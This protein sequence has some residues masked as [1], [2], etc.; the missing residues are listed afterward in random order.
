MTLF[1]F[2][3]HWFALCAAL[4]V[5][6]IYVA[7]HLAFRFSPKV[8]Y[9]GIPVLQTANED[10]Y[11]TRIREVIDGHY[12]TG[13]FTFY[14]YKDK[15]PLTP[16]TIEFFYALP[17][18]LFDIPY[19][20]TAVASRF[21]LPAILFVLVY[22]L[23]FEMTKG[24]KGEQVDTKERR[25]KW[26]RWNALA[27]A[28]VVTLGYDLVDYRALFHLL[29]TG[30][31]TTSNLLFWS[32]LVH[33][34]SGAVLLF[35]CLLLTWFLI[36]GT[37]YRKWV[38]TG[39]GACL[40]LMF[41]SY[42][43][44]WGVALSV[45]AVATLIY[46]LKKEYAIVRNLLLSVAAGM[47]LST[48]YWILVFRTMQEPLYE[49]SALR[50]GL[51]Y[52]HY[53]LFNKFI[54]GALALFL[55]LVVIMPVLNAWRGSH[56][57]KNAMRHVVGSF[58]PWHFFTL[59]LLLGSFWV[60]VEQVVTGI[61]AWPPHFPQYTI[62]VGLVVLF[63][64]FFNQVTARFP[65]AW[66]SFS[67]FIA[68]AALVYGIFIQTYVYR[69]T[70]QDNIDLERIAPMLAFLDAVK[71]PCVALV[72]KPSEGG[73]NWNFIVT[74]F[75]HCDTYAGNGVS[76]IVPYERVL[77][78]YLTNVRIGGLTSLAFNEFLRKNPDHP[79]EY[80]FGSWKGIYNIQDFPDFYDVTEERMRTLPDDYRDFLTQDFREQL[81]KY[82]L[83]YILSVGQP[84]P[85]SVLVEL[86]DTTLLKTF[87]EFYIYQ[88]GSP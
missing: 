5:G 76:L 46:I 47:L 52:T 88:F 20:F 48:P 54:L 67:T 26:A 38:V 30:E 25:E 22:F 50:G 84:L 69:G 73:R 10:Y 16:P 23:I 1:F 37:L 32:R 56:N 79:R 15:L 87:G 42:F 2:K 65:R 35:A 82:R 28:F 14:E 86:P 17:T 53:P 27:G 59:A 75:T 36:R 83:D 71:G 8:E 34:I 66:M 7:P 70:F 60:Y 55:F 63:T 39:A 6:V 9:Q 44:S 77:H 72:N 11:L 78:N 19:T 40:A 41:A 80:L 21:V 43:F 31:P 62:P 74:A 45:F 33:P 58:L 24:G 68:A 4:I 57:L 3:K 51:F 18:L 61:T 85:P 29:T 13:S 81:Q 64:L 49:E 12:S